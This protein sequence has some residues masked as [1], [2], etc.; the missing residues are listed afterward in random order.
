MDLKRARVL[1]KSAQQLAESAPAPQASQNAVS[2]WMRHVKG[3]V[4]SLSDG[5]SLTRELK[6]SLA[7]DQVGQ[8]TEA[9]LWLWRNAAS[10]FANNSGA[11]SRIRLQVIAQVLEQLAPIRTE[12]VFISFSHRDEKLARAFHDVL[13]AAGAAPFLSSADDGGIAGGEAFFAELIAAMQNADS[14]VFL[15]TRSSV[16]E[17]WGAFEIG[18]V[19]AR[20]KRALPIM[21]DVEPPD[22]P[23]P[24]QHI[25]G[26]RT[27]EP[28]KLKAKL[29]ELVQSTPEQWRAAEPALAAFLALASRAKPNSA[30]PALTTLIAELREAEIEA[31]ATSTIGTMAA[32]DA[33]RVQLHALGDQIRTFLGS[34]DADRLDEKK[35]L[36]LGQ[37]L[38]ST[39]ALEQKEVLDLEA[40]IEF[41]RWAKGLLEGLR[42]FLSA[43]T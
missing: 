41:W 7:P 22:L 6:D 30:A 40:M 37:A 5:A 15:A 1:L 26:V 35:R 12:R 16:R 14:L 11:D 28:S 36:E 31:Q 20:G 33:F 39:R 2:S 32:V 9:V 24:V 13:L 29:A 17:H 3:L 38:Q 8:M 21:I 18:A 10:H 42:R 25:Q 27:S 43:M 34:S 4:E 19:F 23:A